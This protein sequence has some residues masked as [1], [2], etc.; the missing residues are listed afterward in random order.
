MIWQLRTRRFD[1]P[2]HPGCGA[3][4]LGIV[5]VTPDSFSDGGRHAT[6]EG[7]VVHALQLAAEGADLLDIGGESSRPGALPI[8]LE[9]ELAR[10]IP[11]V[12]ELTQRTSVPLSIDTVRAEVAHQALEAGAEVINDITAMQGDPRMAEVVQTHRAG[13]ILMHMQGTPATMQLN[14]TYDEQRGGVVIEVLEFLKARLHAATEAGIAAERV[15]LDP[16]IGFGKTSHHNWQLLVHL[17]QLRQLG[18]P[19]CLGVSRKGFLG[20]KVDRPV[21]Q[22]LGSSLACVA[23]ALERQAAQVFRVHD[24][25][26]THDLIRV[27][28]HLLSSP[29]MEP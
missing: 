23:H 15:V 16:G 13:V 28:Q 21:G 14:P 4:V 5:N 20:R 2:D 9:E 18:R 22:R 26:A 11:V 1:W 29:E 19:V 12:R 6:T 7:A 8:S 25:A 3:F 27:Y 17:Q 10:V 24:V